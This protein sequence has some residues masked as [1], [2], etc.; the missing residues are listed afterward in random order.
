MD[1]KGKKAGRYLLAAIAATVLAI[2]IGYSSTLHIS[3]VNVELLGSP[4]H[5]QNYVALPYFRPSEA[6]KSL[7]TIT[8]TINYGMFSS[9]LLRIAPDNCI[10]SIQLNGNDVASVKKTSKRW[11]CFPRRYTIDLS[12][13]LRLGANSLRIDLTDRDTDKGGRYGI[14]MW[15]HYSQ[16][17]VLAMA[18]CVGLALY[19][20][21]VYLLGAVPKLL[22]FVSSGIGRMCVMSFLPCLGLFA[23]WATIVNRQEPTW[24]EDHIVPTLAAVIVPIVLLLRLLDEAGGRPLRLSR[25]YTAAAV[26][27]TIVAYASMLLADRRWSNYDIQG[28]AVAGVVAGFFASVPFR[29]FL[30]R[31]PNYPRAVALTVVAALSPHAY[32]YLNLPLWGQMSGVTSAMVRGI[33]LVCG[34]SALNARTVGAIVARTCSSVVSFLRILQG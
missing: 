13:H 27:L 20:G 14:D 9:G 12:P 26:S 2:F 6:G 11:R 33:L 3:R 16:S 28:I 24:P 4:A 34:N 10:K 18:A 17:A 32:W 29:D 21:A 23:M 8:A 1:T 22:A 15:G 25:S 5:H 19:A 7:F 31:L 30:K